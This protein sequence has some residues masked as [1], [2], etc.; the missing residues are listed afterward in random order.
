MKKPKAE[1]P[2]ERRAWRLDLAALVLLVAGLLVALSL[3]TDEPAPGAKVA[4]TVSFIPHRNV[5]GTGGSWLAQVLTETMGVAVYV[6]LIIWFVL[7]VVLFL[8][9]GFFISSL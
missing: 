6:L 1:N 2:E 9:T 5:L 3:F 8:L 4:A 7:V